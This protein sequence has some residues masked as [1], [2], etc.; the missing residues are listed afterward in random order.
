VQKHGLCVVNSVQVMYKNKVSVVSSYCI[1]F[2]HT[3]YKNIY[4]ICM[5]RGSH[6]GTYFNECN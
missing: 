6:S 1:V 3:L 4:C 2:A 5:C